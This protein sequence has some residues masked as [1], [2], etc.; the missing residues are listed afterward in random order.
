[1]TFVDCTVREEL[2][3]QL[4]QLNVEPTHDA[5]RRARDHGT[6]NEGPNPSA[7]KQVLSTTFRKSI[8][9]SGPRGALQNCTQGQFDAG[10]ERTPGERRAM[11]VVRLA[12]IEPTTLGF[13]GQY[14]IH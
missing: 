14:S 2:H 1:V 4:Q 7:P 13:G 6:L 3:L 10:R 12:G 11:K 8:R 5:R 9:V